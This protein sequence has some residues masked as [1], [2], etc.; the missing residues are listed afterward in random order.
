MRDALLPE[1]PVLRCTAKTPSPTTHLISGRHNKTHI[2]NE[3]KKILITLLIISFVVILG[4]GGY[5][6]RS[7]QQPSATTL[8]QPQET[9]NNLPTPQT[10]PGNRAASTTE[11]Q[12]QNQQAQSLGASKLVLVSKT[13]ALDYFA[14]KTGNVLIV[15]LDGKPAEISGGKTDVLNNGPISEIIGASFS[16]DGKKIMATL[17]NNKLEIFDIDQKVWTLLPNAI[18]SASW[19]PDSHKIAF[20]SPGN[21]GTVYI[22]DTDNSKAKQSEVIKIHQQDININWTTSSTILLR[23]SSSASWKSSLWSLDIT[24]KTLMPV[25]LDKT[26]LETIWSSSPSGI[27]LVMVSNINGLGGQLQLV[28]KTGKQ[29]RLLNFLTLPSKCTFHDKIV[30]TETS[31]ATSTSPTSSS[32]TTST[33]S[34]TLKKTSAAA[35]AVPKI[36]TALTMLCAIP[37]DANLL[38]NNALPDAYQKRDIFTSDDFF[39]INISTGNIKNIFNDQGKDIDAE[40]LKVFNQSLFF[41][42]RFDKLIYSLP[43]DK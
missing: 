1:E 40:N 34:S 3:M 6:L 10:S 41:L 7:R 13:Q 33:S 30:Q 19:S 43:L 18:Q 2:K 31:I 22:L 23:D 38:D 8:S 28:N 36:I 27:G 37:R 39:E 14:G 11:Q 26:G 29:A 16:F 32:S 35:S 4:I 9:Q 25:L 5:Y 42:N 21:P 17:G 12:D 20:L 15:Q 24:K